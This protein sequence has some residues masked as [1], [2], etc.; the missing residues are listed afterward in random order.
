[1]IL[2]TK[3]RIPQNTGNLFTSWGTVSFARNSLL[4]AASAAGRGHDVSG[5]HEWELKI[6]NVVT[7]TSAH[8]SNIAIYY[9]NV[10]HSFFRRVRK[11]RKATISF[12]TEQLGSHSRSS[13][14]F[15]FWI[16]SQNFRE[17]SIFTKIGKNKGYCT[18]RPIY[19]FLIISRSILLRMRNVSNLYKK[20]KQ[21]LFLVIF[22]FRKSCRL[23]DYV[24]K[25]WEAVQAT[26]IACRVTN[27]IQT[28]TSKTNTK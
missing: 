2:V 20:S 5:L 9:A 15:D 3:L 24:E 21:I 10:T 22:F 25:Y 13:M 1:M 19:I 28:L 16:F 26:R 11:L 18:C 23:C 8:Y 27:V 7:A 12:V 17:I 4:H 14:K 6:R